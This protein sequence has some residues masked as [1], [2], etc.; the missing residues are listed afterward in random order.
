[1]AEPHTPPAASTPSS[2]QLPEAVLI[3]GAG[4]EV[5]HGLI[6]ALHNA[7]V[8][9]V[10][11]DM[12]PLP[13][14]SRAHCR[15]QLEGDVC[16][17]SLLAPLHGEVRITTIYHLAALLS[18]ASERDPER[19]QRVNVEGTLALF[20]FARVQA[21]RHGEPVRFIYPSSIAVFGLPDLDTKHRAGAVVEGVYLDPITMYG[22]NKLY[23]EHLGRY[24]ARHYRQIEQPKPLPPI[25]FRCVR[26]PGLISAETVPTGGTSDFA[27]EM[28]H[29][30]AQGKPYACF[31]REDARI[32]F[33]TM[34]DAI[35][36]TLAL[37]N[38]PREQLRQCIY[39]LGAFAP[40][41][42]EFAGL[43][44]QAFPDAQITFDAIHP[45]RQGIV[46]S[47]PADV[48][49]SAAARDFGF[50]PKHDLQAAFD[51]Y[52]VPAIRRRYGA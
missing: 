30:A 51:H 48:D 5:G 15:W 50:R 45:V 27:P 6:D 25:D 37:A 34:P 40:T 31:V 33:M 41:A 28:L 14:R 10:A 36:A 32:P 3:T 43:V 38:A 44:R 20:E 29:A 8:D 9:V 19:A 7:G 49:A 35:A 42:G 47:W 23:V 26:Y 16:D 13:E 18:T 2:E 22:C 17:R 52:L 1:M 4:G 12:R 21:Q 11:L 24:H 46:D 39:N